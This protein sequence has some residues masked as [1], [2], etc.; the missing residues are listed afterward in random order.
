[1]NEVVPKAATIGML[2]NP[3]YQQSARQVTD[4]EE[5]ARSVLENDRAVALDVLVVLDAGTCRREQLFEPG[6]ACMQRLHHPQAAKKSPS[7]GANPTGARLTADL[8][9]G[10]HAVAYRDAVKIARHFDETRRKSNLSSNL[11]APA[12]R[13]P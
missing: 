9:E 5:A 6:F 13:H 11:P 4:V 8:R 12:G 2:V 7:A 3:A 10:P 1:L